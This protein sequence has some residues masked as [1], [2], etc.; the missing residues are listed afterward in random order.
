MYLDKRVTKHGIEISIIDEENFVQ[1]GI[2]ITYEDFMSLVCLNQSPVE[3]DPDEDRNTAVKKLLLA[4][5]MYNEDGTL[6][7]I[8]WGNQLDGLKV[9]FPGK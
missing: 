5:G 2:T 9:S 1:G 3:D 6:K 8:E 4:T 7:D